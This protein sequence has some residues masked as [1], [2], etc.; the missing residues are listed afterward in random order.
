M[1][2][3]N[4]IGLQMKIWEGSFTPKVYNEELRPTLNWNFILGPV[5]QDRER[6]GMSLCTQT[7]AAQTDAT[8]ERGERGDATRIHSPGNRD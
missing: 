6:Q 1:Y 8:A 4:W 2:L 5:S 3:S 7:R